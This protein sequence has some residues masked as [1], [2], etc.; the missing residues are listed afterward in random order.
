MTASFIFLICSFYCVSA[1]S[2]TGNYLYIELQCSLLF[3]FLHVCTERAALIQSTIAEVMEEDNRLAAQSTGQHL[4]SSLRKL[5]AFKQATPE[6]QAHGSARLRFEKMVKIAERKIIEEERKAVGQDTTKLSDS[7]TQELLNNPGDILTAQE[8]YDVFQSSGCDAYKDTTSYDCSSDK[9]RVWRRPNGTCNNK[10]YPLYGAAN[11]PM[12][13]LLSPDYED[14]ISQPR[15]FFQLQGLGLGL[16]STAFDSPNPSP[17]LISTIA[18]RDV[19]REDPV[20]SLMLMQFAQ[21]M[22]HDLDFMPEYAEDRC[23]SC[24]INTDTGACLPILIP[25]YD[26]RM[27]EEN[28]EECLH[29]SRS[30]PV[31]G[32]EETDSE[33][34]E[35]LLW[36]RNHM[37]MITHFIDA[38]TVYHHDPDF[39]NEQLRGED[40]KLKMENEKLIIG[41]HSLY[42]YVYCTTFI[43]LHFEVFKASTLQLLL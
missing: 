23:T 4:S 16:P 29:F 18:I 38:S 33:E 10:D 34:D 14:G 42:V 9:D 35:Y 12:K 3:M 13:R 30:L 1:V 26:S 24:D 25:H 11:S 36:P 2:P 43:P 22:D 27:E 28:A 20:H 37:N 21:F 7:Y 31:C 41:E 8:I 32:A 6:L 15:G 5:R 39:L 40:G 19:E 17:R